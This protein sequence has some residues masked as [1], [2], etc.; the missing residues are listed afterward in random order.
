MGVR[1]A[2]VVDEVGDVGDAA[3][4]KGEEEAVVTIARD[5]S[6]DDDADGSAVLEE[7]NAELFASRRPKEMVRD[8]NGAIARGCR[9]LFALN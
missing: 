1:R 3:T 2:G 5:S 9:L 4:R 6:D 8:T 7:W